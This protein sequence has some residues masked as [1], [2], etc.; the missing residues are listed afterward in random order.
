M[1]SDISEIDLRQS[2]NDQ[3]Q[4]SLTTKSNK[5][6]PECNEDLCTKISQSAAIK[7]KWY[8]FVESTTLHGL[9]YVFTSP[10]LVRRILW[11]VFLLSGIAFFSYQSSKLIRKYLSYST[12]TKVNLVYED[13]LE[14]PAVTICN[15]N[16]FKKSVITAKG[17]DKAFEFNMKKAAGLNTSNDTLDLSKYNDVNMTE[18]YFTAGHQIEDTLVSCLWLVG[19]KCDHKN[20]TAVL[21]SMGLCHT[22]TSGKKVKICFFLSVFM[23]QQSSFSMFCYE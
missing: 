4:N 20:F 15:F 6:I 11:T 18:F 16:T 10:T 21:T 23:L 1:D 3:K 2:N 19:E 12:A 5:V 7:Q 14:F 13:I 8:S 17:Y 9:Q 22:F